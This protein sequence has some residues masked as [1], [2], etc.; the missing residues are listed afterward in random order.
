MLMVILVAIE[1]FFNG[2]M[3]RGQPLLFLGVGE[4]DRLVSPRG[5]NV[6][7]WVKDIDA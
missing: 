4:V 6:E 3:K 2:R 7:L 1:Q 5:S